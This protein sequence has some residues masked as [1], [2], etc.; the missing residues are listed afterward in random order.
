MSEYKVFKITRLDPL[1]PTFCAAKWLSADFYLH[2]GRTSSCHLPVPDKIDLEQAKTNIHYFNNT[3]EK[4]EQKAEMLA[5]NKPDKCSNC[6]QVESVAD[7]VSERIIYSSKFGDYNFSKLD[8]TAE[9]APTTISVSFDTLCNF[10]CSYCDASQSSRWATDLATNGP[11]KK[12]YKDPRMTY[13]R[14]GKKELVDDYDEVFNLFLQY[15]DKIKPTLHIVN[16]L[17]GEPLISPNFWQ[18]VDHLTQF[19]CSHIGLS[20][21]TNLS[22]LENVKRLLSYKEKFRKISITASIE[23]T[24]TRAEF[25]RAGLNWNTF[26]SNLQWLQS[27]DVEVNLAATCS[28]VA[29]DGLVD[30]LEWYINLNFVGLNIFRLRHPNFQVMQVLPFEMRVNYNKDILTWIE[31]NYFKIDT[32]TLEQIR[33]ICYTLNSDY[34]TYDGVPIE[35]LQTD[36][37]HFYKQYAER[38]NFK[39]QD[40]FSKNLSDW[41]LN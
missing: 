19:D 32:E 37:K 13:Q 20:V 21:V 9:Q 3:V 5:G 2:T 34:K 22:D 12:I 36:A 4:L 14:L 15:V 33:N 23:N 40:I 24:N 6:W 28:L 10:A 16:C 18:F 39:I 17:G 8:N 27:Q 29:L 31:K 25:L 38:N 11:Y 1:S 30:F 26:K 35:L 41:L 7:A